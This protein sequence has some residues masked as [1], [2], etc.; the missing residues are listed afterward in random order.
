MAPFCSTFSQSFIDAILYS[1]FHQS[2]SSQGCCCH[3]FNWCWSRQD[4]SHHEEGLDQD[5]ADDDF[6][7][8]FKI[9]VPVFAQPG[10][11]FLDSRLERVV[12]SFDAH[13][14]EKN[15]RFHCSFAKASAAVTASFRIGR[16]LLGPTLCSELV[17]RTF[18][19]CSYRLRSIADAVYDMSI[20]DT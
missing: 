18:I 16:A 1:S 7:S 8:L 17:Q 15:S 9:D 12:Q 14:L 10:Q 19:Y 3:C 2:C 4:E 11:V 20:L 13:Q 6:F 5:V